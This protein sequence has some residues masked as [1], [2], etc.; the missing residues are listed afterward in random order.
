MRSKSCRASLLPLSLSFLSTVV[1]AQAVVVPGVMNGVEGGGG[2]SIPFGS[3]L[4]CRYQVVYDAQ[5]L[6]WTGPRLI[7]GI[8][9][10]ADNGSPTTPGVAIA[11]KGY[12]ELS[13]RLS[14][15]YVS[16]A[17]LGATFEDNHGMDARWVMLGERIVL[18]AQ[19]VTATPGPRPANLDLNFTT[20]WFYGL[21]PGRGTQPPPA[22][23]LIE[24]LITF[25]PSGSYR[26]DNLNGCHAQ[27][28]DFGNQ[29]PQCT[30]PGAAGSPQL[31]TSLSMQAGSQ[32]GWTLSNAAPSGLWMLMVNSTNVGGL[33]GQPSMALPYPLF[34]PSN[35]SVPPAGLAALRWSAPDCW[36]NL[37]PVGGFIGVCDS[38]GSGTINTPIP[39]GQQ[40]IGFTLFGQAIALAPSANLLGV[41]TTRGRHSTVCGPLAVSRVH[42]FY[43]NTAVPPPQPPTSGAVQFGVGAVVEV[44]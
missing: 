14:T 17:T 28:V 23:L 30:V 11:Q 4:A 29:D 16:S 25:Q 12:V 22:N 3:N 38:T 2:T 1:T 9:I 27:A 18:P 19:P 33:F 13:V 26:I 15:T 43:D 34:D 41:V 39:A 20:P 24:I 7:N 31:T 5:E 35:P 10:R 6:P 8:S 21:T 44:R 36:M 37:D 32:F 42:Q 40:Y